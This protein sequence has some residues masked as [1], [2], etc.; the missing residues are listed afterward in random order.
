VPLGHEHLK[1]DHFAL[2]VSLGQGHHHG[3]VLPTGCYLV[4]VLA[5]ARRSAAFEGY[6]GTREETGI[7]KEWAHQGSNLGLFACKANALPLSYAP[8]VLDVTNAD[9]IRGAGGF[10]RPG[11]L[12]SP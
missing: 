5:V 3:H 10:R 9:S 12:V 7:Q 4:P 1:L 6:R 2:R 11:C 8:V